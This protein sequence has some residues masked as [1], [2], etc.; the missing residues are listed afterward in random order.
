MGVREVTHTTSQRMI[1]RREPISRA[2][3]LYL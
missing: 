2:W 1:A 3:L